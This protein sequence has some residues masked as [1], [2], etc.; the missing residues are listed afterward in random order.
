[1]AARAQAPCIL[2]NSR[3]TPAWSD[4]QWVCPVARRYC[5]GGKGFTAGNAVLNNDDATVATTGRIHV[6]AS[7]TLRCDC[8]PSFLRPIGSPPVWHRTGLPE[9]GRLALFSVRNPSSGWFELRWRGVAGCIANAL[10]ETLLRRGA[11]ADRVRLSRK[12]EDPVGCRI[13]AA[14]RSPAEPM[15]VAASREQRFIDGANDPERS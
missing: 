12:R 7:R 8:K 1:M 14:R 10:T 6:P 9:A 3:T 5:V 15:A 11:D 2:T 4:L 13:S